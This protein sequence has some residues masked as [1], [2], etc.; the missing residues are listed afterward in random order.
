MK[1]ID[2]LLYKLRPPAEALYMA[3]VSVD[4]RTGLYTADCRTWSGNSH[5]TGGS[6]I[7][8]PGL[9]TKQD[10]LEEIDRIEAKF[11]GP[12][13]VIIFDDLDLLE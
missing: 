1:L 13:A 2:R 9:L 10:A 12:S 5:T 3:F 7:I 6:R 11:P 4:S 8:T